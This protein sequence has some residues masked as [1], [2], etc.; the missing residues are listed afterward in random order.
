[1]INPLIAIVFFL[2]SSGVTLI[3]GFCAVLVHMKWPDKKLLPPP[4]KKDKNA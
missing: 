3:G 2:L 1:M 4:I